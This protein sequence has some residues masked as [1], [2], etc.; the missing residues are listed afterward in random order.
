MARVDEEWQ[1]FALRNFGIVGIFFTSNLVIFPVAVVV[2]CAI[3]LDCAYSFL[4]VPVGP[5]TFEW[6]VTSECCSFSVSNINLDVSS[7]V[8]PNLFVYRC[9]AGEWAGVGH[10][11]TNGDVGTDGMR[12]ILFAVVVGST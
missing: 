1:L 10:G 11:I 7:I 9:G 5:C 12:M 4:A 6:A 8:V 3:D 2:V